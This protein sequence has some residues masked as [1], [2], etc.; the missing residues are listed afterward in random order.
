MKSAGPAISAILLVLLTLLLVYVASLGPAILLY[1]H[2]MLSE[3]AAE[4]IYAP[5]ECLSM[6]P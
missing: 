1:S 6:E 3:G 4:A 2:G 5:L